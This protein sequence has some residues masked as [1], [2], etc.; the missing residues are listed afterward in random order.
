MTLTSSSLVD[1]VAVLDRFRR[2]RE[3]TRALFDL[4]DDSVYYDRPIALRNPVVFYEGHLPAF[5]VNTLL[6]RALGRPGIDAHLEE[7]FARGIDP[8]TEAKA[9]ARGNPAWPSRAEVRAYA[10]AADRAIADA[11]ERAELE[12]SRHPMLQRA[13]ALWTILEHEEMHQETLAYMWHEIPYARKRRPDGYTTLAGDDGD[14]RLPPNFPLTRDTGLGAGNRELGVDQALQASIPAGT[15]SLGTP[16]DASAFAWDNELDAHDVEVPAFAI[17]VH[18]VT[19][20]RFMAFV[21]AGG[22]RDPRWW[23]PEDWAWL[24]SQSMTHPH[25]WVR[26]AGGWR[27]RARGPST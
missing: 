12:S 5:A 14:S 26:T 1:R 11:I 10:A 23:R 8:E 9:A 22:Y 6:K 21:E 27:W 25:F 4:L 3:R 24:A 7:I 15:A 20:A 13:Q 19:N 2:I 16:P 17:D 18:N